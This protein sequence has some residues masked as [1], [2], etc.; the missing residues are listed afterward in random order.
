MV[1]QVI[2]MLQEKGLV[3]T[4]M[5]SPQEYQSV[6][7]DEAFDILLKRSEEVNK[8]TRKEVRD[9]LK[10]LRKSQKLPQNDCP[11]IT[12]IPKGK[13][14][15]TKIIDELKNTETNVDI[16]ISW[17]KFMKWNRI[18]TKE[19]INEVMKRDVKF[20]VII[21][22]EIPQ[23]QAPLMN[24]TVFGNAHF[25]S[26]EVKVMPNIQLVNMIIFDNKKAF[27]DVTADG[28]LLETPSLFSNNPCLVPL[29]INY[30]QTNW[31]LATPLQNAKIELQTALQM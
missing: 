16:V 22:K 18:Y 29:A 1:Y 6:S 30:F 28:G 20:Q 27:I 3:E 2:P 23:S 25:D 13:A 10:V 12:V 19:K 21:E 5:S 9:S 14:L 31:T 26:Y 15:L 24:P 8:K 11:Q 17:Q 4:V 7:I